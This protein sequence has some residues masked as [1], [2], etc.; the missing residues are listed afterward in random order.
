[1]SVILAFTAALI[2]ILIGV[3]RARKPRTVERPVFVKRYV[4]PGHTWARLTDDG[5]VV[6][7][8]D[9][10]AQAVI[11]TIDGIKLPRLLR[12][13]RQGGVGWSVTH[14]NRIVPM[15]SP[16]DGWVVEKNEMVLGNP[17][18]VNTAPYGDGWLFKVRPR[19]IKVQQ[20]NLFTGKVAQQWQDAARAQL[21][22]FFTGTPALMYQDGGVLIKNLCDRCSDDEWKK[23]VEQFFL[24][25]GV[26]SNKEI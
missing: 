15:L 12:R 8:V 5:Y 4:H 9:E 16:V 22:R 26:T 13:V 23:I 6:V 24:V 2:L 19:K 11:G 10:F 18:L 20:A 14:G 25:E 21:N 1:M 17:S 3:V 7:G